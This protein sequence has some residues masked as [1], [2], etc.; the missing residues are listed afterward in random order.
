MGA[1]KE[2]CGPTLRRKS[3]PV[4]CCQWFVFASRHLAVTEADNNSVISELPKS[5]KA[6]G[7]KTG[8][9]RIDS[10]ALQ[11]GWQASATAAAARHAAAKTRTWSQ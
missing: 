8:S 7:V 1:G 4:R 11:G 5:R 9:Q 3:E 10:P 2:Q 6:Q